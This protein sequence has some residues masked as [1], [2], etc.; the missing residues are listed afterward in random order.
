MTQ[1]APGQSTTTSGTQSGANHDQ[2]RLAR[3]R[4]ALDRIDGEAGHNVIA[5]LADIAPDFA[6][7]VIEF[8]FGDI[9]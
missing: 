3:G 4:R 2:D 1:S 5:A 6:T 8:P 7:Y 9:Y